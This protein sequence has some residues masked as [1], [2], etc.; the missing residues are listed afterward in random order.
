MHQGETAQ[1]AQGRSKYTSDKG[2]SSAQHSTAHQ[3]LG[4]QPDALGSN[5]L[6]ADLPPHELLLVPLDLLLSKERRQHQ[7]GQAGKGARTGVTALAEMRDRHI[8]QRSKLSSET[9]YRV[10]FYYC[11]GVQAKLL[12]AP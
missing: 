1:I 5:V 8:H 11:C 12:P 10:I 3:H 4:H 6:D 7:H 9:I 2:I